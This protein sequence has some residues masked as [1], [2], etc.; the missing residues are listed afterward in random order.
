MTR[1]WAL[2][3]TLH[4]AGNSA[5]SVTPSGCSMPSWARPVRTVEFSS[6]REITQASIRLA[7]RSFD[8]SARAS[9]S[10]SVAPL[11][12]WLISSSAAS[13]ST[14]SSR[15]RRSRAFSTATAAWSDRIWTSRRS[16]SLKRRGMRARSAI[17]PLTQSSARIGT[18]S[19]DHAPGRVAPASATCGTTKGAP[20]VSAR[21]TAL[22][23]TPSAGTAAR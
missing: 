10:S 13:S 23:G 8:A 3:R 16:S 12:A 22:A 5:I 18:T 1:G 15:A 21:Q 19:I 14:S 6:Q 4:V 20:L 17:T 7:A 11:V 9:V 2:R